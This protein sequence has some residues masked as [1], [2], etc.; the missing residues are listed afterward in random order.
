MV[1]PMKG[2]CKPVIAR[3]LFLRGCKVNSFFSLTR[4]VTEW[5]HLCEQSQQEYRQAF[6]LDT[7]SCLSRPMFLVEGNECILVLYE[8]N[9]FPWIF[10]LKQNTQLVWYIGYIRQEIMYGVVV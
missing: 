5:N 2:F 8:D 7:N 4:Q 9:D 10:R 6:K 3:L 1:R